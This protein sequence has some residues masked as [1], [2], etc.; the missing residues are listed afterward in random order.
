MQ[1]APRDFN[2]NAIGIHV[3]TRNDLHT[4]RNAHD[5]KCIGL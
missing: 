4:Q 1:R 3:D 2:R 5:V